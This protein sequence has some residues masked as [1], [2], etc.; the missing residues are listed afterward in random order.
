M[1]RNAFTIVPASAG[2]GPAIRRS[3]RLRLPLIGLASALLSLILLPSRSFAA[4]LQV[5]YAYDSIGRLTSATYDDSVTLLYQYDR[6]GNILLIAAGSTSAAPEGP[7]PRPLSFQASQPFPNPLRAATEIAYALPHPLRVDLAIFDV[8]GRL[9]RS[10]VRETQAGG[11]Y[12]A[13][14][15]G[16]D[17]AGRPVA[18]GV[19][20]SRL[21]AGPHRKTSRIV[22]AR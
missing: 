15:N 11:L 10:L 13:V 5:T 2:P 21:Q 12:S 17:D 19:Y 18:D 8:S 1:K 22:V 4:P 16:F 14:W 9:I 6:S 3:S 7:P 20:F